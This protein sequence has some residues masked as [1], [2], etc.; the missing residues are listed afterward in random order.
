MSAWEDGGT[1]ECW[2]STVL[3]AE[4]GQTGVG[5]KSG[6]CSGVGLGEAKGRER[7]QVQKPSKQSGT[8]GLSSEMWSWGRTHTRGND[9]RQNSGPGQSPR[10]TRGETCTKDGKGTTEE[11]AGQGSGKEGQVSLGTQQLAS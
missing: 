10:N 1:T 5:S 7:P 11:E 4:L 6:R 3:L 8:W 2:V 9:L